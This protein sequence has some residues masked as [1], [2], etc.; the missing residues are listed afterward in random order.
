MCTV[1][2]YNTGVG[3]VAKALTNRTKLKPASRKANNMSNKKL[4]KT[5]LSDLE[6]EETR[7]YL[8]RVWTLKEKYSGIG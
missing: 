8:K 1:A 3:N 5:L 2:A 4:Y 6:Y 7:K